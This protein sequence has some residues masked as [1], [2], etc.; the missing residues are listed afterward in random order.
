VICS[1]NKVAEHVGR[2]KFLLSL[3]FPFCNKISKNLARRLAI[4]KNIC[5][6]V[7]QR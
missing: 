6:Y 2:D 1:N 5:Y 3:L 7:G 4:A